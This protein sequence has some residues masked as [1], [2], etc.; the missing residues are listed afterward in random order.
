MKDSA[1]SAT[2][3]S[4]HRLYD[5]NDELIGP[6]SGQKARWYIRKQ[7]VDVIK[8]TPYYHLRLNYPLATQKK[9]FTFHYSAKPNT[10]VVC[11]Y[12]KKISGHH[13]VPRCFV[14]FMPEKYKIHN[15]HDV[16]PICRTCHNVYEL[17]ADELKKEICTKLNIN[18]DYGAVITETV[19]VVKLSVSYVDP[20]IDDTVRFVLRSKI[21]Q[22]LNRE[23]K[24][25]E[26]KLYSRMTMWH[27]RQAHKHFGEAVIEQTADLN[28]FAYL[29]RQHFI[30]TMN[31]KFLHLLEGWEV[32]R[33]YA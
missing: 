10:C 17:H 12:D 19:R 23:V 15:S 28:E 33:K 27:I 20:R 2:R 30:K 8:D 11:G 25:Q 7:L 16:I 21:E 24:E 32:D 5:Q 9:V 14:R 6:M 22:T 1:D 4:D 18:H 26:I 3:F 13:I 29:W 31:P